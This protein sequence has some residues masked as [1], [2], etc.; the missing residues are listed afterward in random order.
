MALTVKQ[1]TARQVVPVGAGVWHERVVEKS[2][3]GE[4][5]PPPKEGELVTSSSYV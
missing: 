4:R 3:G 2:W 5:E 1:L